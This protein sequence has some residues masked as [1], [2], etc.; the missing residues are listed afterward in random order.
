MQQ[1]H[2]FPVARS[3]KGLALIDEHHGLVNCVISTHTTIITVVTGSVGIQ[4]RHAIDLVHE[5]SL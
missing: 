3:P 4:R 5:A 1:E 2:F